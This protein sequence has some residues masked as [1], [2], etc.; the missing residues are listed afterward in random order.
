VTEQ[1]TGYEASSVAEIGAIL[2]ASPATADDVYLDTMNYSERAIAAVAAK[3]SGGGGAAIQ[4]HNYYSNGGGDTVPTATPTL[5]HWVDAGGETPLLSLTIP[6]VPAVVT[7]GV[8]AV[9]LT[10]LSIDG[11]FAGKTMAVQLE[12]DASNDDV[13]AATCV[14]LDTAMVLSANRV[15]AA[16]AVTYFV[17]DAGTIWATVE[18]DIGEDHVFG[19]MAIV[20]RL[21]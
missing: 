4:T 6:T 13:S 16:V 19:L 17:P 5:L 12:L 18:H 9:G 21:S 7:A 2:D 15:A 3:R 14:P 8:Y 20:Q 10:V 1:L 11:A